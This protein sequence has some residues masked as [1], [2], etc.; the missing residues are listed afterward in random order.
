MD[1]TIPPVRCY[2]LFPRTCK[3]AKSLLG[4]HSALSER[5]WNTTAVGYF[6]GKRPYFHHLNDHVRSIWP[7]VRE[8]TAT[9]NGFFFFHFSMVTAME[10]V[11]VW[12][13]LHDLP[14]ELW[15]TEGLSIVASGIGKPLYPDAITRACTRLD[16][17]R[18]YVILDISSK[19]PKHV[20]IM[21]PKEDGS[22]MACKVDIE[23]EWLPPKCNT[24]MTLGHATKVCL[25]L[26]PKK[27]V[28]SVYVQKADACKPA[29]VVQSLES[30]L[31]PCSVPTCDVATGAEG[32][33][34]VDTSDKAHSQGL[35]INAA[36]WNVRGLNRRDHQVSVSTLI[37]EQRLHFVGL[38]ETRVSAINVERVKRGVH[39]RWNWFIDYAGPASR[40]WL[41]WDDD[42]VD[43]NVLEVDIQYVLCRVLIR[44]IHTH[45]LLTIVYGFNELGG[46]RVLWQNLSNISHAIVDIPWLVGGDFNT[47]L[48][49]SEVCGHSGDIRCAAEEFQ[50][51]IHETGL[52]SLPMQGEWFT[53]HNCS[54]DSRSLWK[55]LDCILVNDCWLDTWPNSVYAS[56]NART[57]DHSPLVLR[58]NVPFQTVSMFWFDNYLTMSS[59]FTLTV[60]RV[61]QHHIV[62]ATMFGVTRKL[63][64]LK[65]IFRKQ[66]Q[67]KGDLSNNV[68]LAAS[69]LETA[70][71]LLARDRHSP[72]LLHLQFSCKLVLR[73]ATKLEQQML[74]QRAK[75]AWMKGGDQ[76]SRIF[77]HKDVINEF[78]AFY[79]T[80]L[81]GDR[82]ARMIDLCYL[83]P[84]ARHT[85]TEDEA[86]QLICRVTPDEVKQ[87]VFD[88]AEDKAPGLD[89]YSSGFFKAAWPVIGK[90]V[91]Q[92]ILDFFA[93]GRLLKQVNATL[94]SLIPKV[95]NPTLVAE[96][97]PISCCKMLYKVITKIIVQ[98]LSGLLDKIISP[99]QNAFVLGRCIGDNILLAQELFQ[100][101]NQQ[102]LP[103]RCAL[104]VD[105]RKAYDTVE[106]DF[107]SAALKLFGFPPLFISWIEECIT[108]PTFSECFNGSPHGFFRGSRGLWQGDPMSPYLLF[109][110]M[111]VLNL[112]LQ[113]IIEQDGG[114]S[115]HWQCEALH[116]FQLGFADDLL[117]FSR[118]DVASVHV[119]KRG[120]SI[121]ADL[122]GLHVNPQKSHLLLSR[123]ASNSREDLLAVLD[124]QEGIFP[125]RYLGLP[126]LAP[127]LTIADC[128]PLLLKI[129]RRLNGWDGIML[130]FARRVQLIKSVRIALQVYWAM[131]FILPKT[132][133][134]AIEKKLRSFLWKGSTGNDYAKV[135]WNQVCWPIEEG[136]LG[137]RNLLALNRGLMS[138][139]LWSI[140]SVDRTSLWVDWMFH[141]RLHSQSVWT[142]SDRTGSWGWRKLLR[143]RVRLQPFVH[144]K[145]GSGVTFS[146]W[147]DP[148]HEMGTLILRF[149]M[150]PRHTA[151]LPTVLLNAVIRD[152]AWSWPLIINI[153]SVEIIHSLSII[154]GGSNC[155]GCSRGDVHLGVC[156]CYLLSTW[157]Q[158]RLVLTTV[159]KV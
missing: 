90:E 49:A 41:A 133:I 76:C 142:V 110:V 19:L 125:L 137:I 118:A 152:G 4:L 131:A 155:M 124:F 36:I 111:E 146:L 109:L 122:S 93:T 108:T 130:S 79:Q 61:W 72:L 117:L 128:K 58:G 59:E 153:E 97:R 20:I 74:H 69:F 44:C 52:I 104:K 10:E 66:R 26:K 136:G 123:A 158:S 33:N 21:V 145:I 45:V 48:D 82:R 17:A 85:I 113:Q 80:L 51:C 88:I 42:F 151:T 106:W 67:K 12:I 84:W 138:K 107:L 32:P 98:W 70:Q 159:G 129:D 96:F 105:I 47:V 24:C 135:S 63:K 18:V 35:M 2:L 27:P 55:K 147:H 148:W 78:V 120:L 144:Y 149:P 154:W 14:V 143:L 29:L 132:I 150:G 7:M 30:E 140:I 139:H 39:P 15:T 23:Y 115:F 75:F 127:R 86:T 114:F 38:L 50:A 1:F 13:K 46:R 134:Q 157:S 71:A 31:E 77:F 101:Y 54:T 102:H 89:G 119:F 73:L 6:L 57:S 121:F 81:G 116:L 43:I 64:A 34:P 126:L 65:P 95:Q 28:A 99:S 68:I 25:T 103:P 91:T 53:W 62:G 3:M 16:F 94:L 87:A 141:Y 11:P 37:S 22:E 83:R 5:R 40:I 92:V 9:S 156:L 100:G 60:Q 112:I 8:V 56:L